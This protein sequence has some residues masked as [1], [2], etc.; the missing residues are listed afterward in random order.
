MDPEAR[1]TPDWQLLPA[2][3]KPLLALPA[4]DQHRAG[5]FSL[6]P[7]EFQLPQ[8][9]KAA[10]YVNTQLAEVTTSTSRF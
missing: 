7:L 8:E 3:G 6:I 9:E 5:P 1:T 4:R 10:Q 2:W